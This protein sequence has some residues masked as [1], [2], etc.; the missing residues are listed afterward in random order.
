[1]E[2]YKRKGKFENIPCCNVLG[3]CSDCGYN[4]EPYISQIK[5]KNNLKK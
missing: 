3:Q 1:M 4:V 5:D 2:Q